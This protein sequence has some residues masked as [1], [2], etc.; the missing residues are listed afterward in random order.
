MRLSKPR[1]LHFCCSSA[2]PLSC[3]Q[4]PCIDCDVDCA[5]P[6]IPEEAIPRLSLKA[7]APTQKASRES[8]VKEAEPSMEK[9][10]DEYTKQ[11]LSDN[12][13]EDLCYFEFI[14]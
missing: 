6:G 8:E 13:R 2:P 9:T 10:H 14:L 4:E 7:K 11:S 5:Q 3:N 12:Q 1:N